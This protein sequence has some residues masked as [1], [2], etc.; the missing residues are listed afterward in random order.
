[1][2]A[3][4]STRGFSSPP[5]VPP[6]ILVGGSVAVSD[7]RWSPSTMTPTPGWRGLN[8]KADVQVAAP[9]CVQQLS[10]TPCFPCVLAP[11]PVTALAGL[12]C[13]W[14]GR[15]IS[16]T[17]ITLRCSAVSALACMFQRMAFKTQKPPEGPTPT[18]PTMSQHPPAALNPEH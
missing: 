14:Y 7:S 11:N 15:G 3:K 16:S 10:L 8:Y 17:S 4:H 12:G 9:A 6:K 5:C 1:M 2:T 13:I 18:H